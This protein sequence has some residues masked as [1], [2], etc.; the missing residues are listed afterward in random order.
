MLKISQ[1]FFK[2]TIR[3]RF[4]VTKHCKNGNSW[5]NV[6]ILRKI[7]HITKFHPILKMIFLAKIFYVSIPKPKTH[8]ICLARKVKHF[9]YMLFWKTKEESQNCP[10]TNIHH[11]KSTR[12]TF[13]IIINIFI[14]IHLAKIFDCFWNKIKR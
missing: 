7:P 11:L 2:N 9:I 1:L 10:E 4:I 5:E 12:V 3:L 8:I 13:W 14:Q 6:E